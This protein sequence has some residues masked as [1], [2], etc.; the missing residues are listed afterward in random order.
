MLTK[1]GTPAAIDI[2]EIDVGKIIRIEGR[3][4][5][6]YSR[7]RGVAWESGREW[8]LTAEQLDVLEREAPAYNADAKRPRPPLTG[9]AAQRYNDLMNEGGE[10]YVP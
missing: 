4:V 6:W 9:D 3:Q 10:G 7:K 2:T 5:Y 1:Q 8:T